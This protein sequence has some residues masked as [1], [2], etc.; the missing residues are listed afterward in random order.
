LRADLSVRYVC[1]LAL[2]AAISI[3]LC[4]RLESFFGTFE[5]ITFAAGFQDM[6]TMRQ[7]IQDDTGESLASKNLRPLI[8]RQIR[9]DDH[10]H[11]F[12]SET[13]SGCFTTTN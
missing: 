5:S 2:Q 1:D 7:A 10:T 12:A 8:K 6:A 13:I 4:G 3:P 11:S 9:R